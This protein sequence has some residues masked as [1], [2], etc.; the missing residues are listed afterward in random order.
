MYE[1]NSIYSRENTKSLWYKLIISTL[2]KSL[3]NSET[4]AIVF[5]DFRLEGWL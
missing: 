4:Y 1:Q 3:S 5:I 2:C